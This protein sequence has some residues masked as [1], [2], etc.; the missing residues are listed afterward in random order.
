MENYEPCTIINVVC[1]FIYLLN[2]QI[3]YE[4]KAVLIDTL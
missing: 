2:S 3:N 4:V 1:V